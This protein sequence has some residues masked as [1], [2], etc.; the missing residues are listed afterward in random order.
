VYK[1]VKGRHLWNIDGDYLG[2]V[3]EVCESIC[4]YV[5]LNGE[6]D[7]FIWRLKGGNKRIDWGKNESCRL[8][9]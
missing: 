9:K 1:P 2:V 6:T 8:H 4:K 7:M 3:T 5:R